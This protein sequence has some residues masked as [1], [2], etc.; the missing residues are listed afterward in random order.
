MGDQDAVPDILN[1]SDP[2]SA[3]A[4]QPPLTTM[5]PH[6]HLAFGDDEVFTWELIGQGLDEPLPC[7][8]VIDE[9]CVGN[10]SKLSCIRSS[11]SLQAPY[12]L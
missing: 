9:L 6:D 10:Q 5:N 2:F 4:T 3:A 11:Q 8:E 1:P 12:L 7:Q